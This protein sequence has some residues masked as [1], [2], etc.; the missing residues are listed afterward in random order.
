[1]EGLII[2]GYAVGAQSNP[3]APVET[4]Q[5]VRYDVPVDDDPFLGSEDAPITIVEFSD[6][7]CPYCRQWHSEVYSQII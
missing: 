5:V 6:Y 7:E 4:P 1:M 2:A 3:D